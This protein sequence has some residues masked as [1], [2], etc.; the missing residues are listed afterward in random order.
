MEW[1]RQM[2]SPEPGYSPTSL[3]TTVERFGEV[4]MW[5]VSPSPMRGKVEEVLVAIPMPVAPVDPPSRVEIPRFLVG[6]QFCH[7]N[8]GTPPKR[9]ENVLAIATQGGNSERPRKQG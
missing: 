5:T 4:A 9:V 6:I 1:D 3:E 7:Q 8:G 2:S